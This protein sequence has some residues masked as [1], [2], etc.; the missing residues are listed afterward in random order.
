MGWIQIS[1][2]LTFLY[3]LSVASLYAWPIAMS[4]GEMTQCRD[5]SSDWFIG[6]VSGMSNAIA[7][8]FYSLWLIARVI[9]TKFPNAD[10]EVKTRITSTG[11][12]ELLIPT[13]GWALASSGSFGKW[14]LFFSLRASNSALVTLLLHLVEQPCEPSYLQRLGAILVADTFFTVLMFAGSWSA[15]QLPPLDEPEKPKDE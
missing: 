7:H 12:H 3:V 9:H 4:S 6:I 1:H 15:D 8:A 2:P 11:E 5:G 13:P 14:C 10:T